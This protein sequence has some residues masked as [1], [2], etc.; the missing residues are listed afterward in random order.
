MKVRQQLSVFIFDVL[1]LDQFRCVTCSS[2]IDVKCV[3]RPAKLQPVPCVNAKDTKCFTTVLSKTLLTHLT[4]KLNK[5][6][7]PDGVTIRGCSS[8]LPNELVISS[9]FCTESECNNNV[10]PENRRVCRQCT[11]STDSTCVDEPPSFPCTI[12]APPDSCFTSFDGELI[13]RGCS[14]DI[15]EGSDVCSGQAYCRVCAGDSCNDDIDDKFRSNFGSQFGPTPV[16]TSAL[17]IIWIAR[18]LILLN[19]SRL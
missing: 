3:Q 15:P 12:F 4:A 17:V 9:E 10:Y 14:S 2:R 13:V 7:L 18:R 6:S 1:F 16:N 19:G 5:N 11:S 8:T